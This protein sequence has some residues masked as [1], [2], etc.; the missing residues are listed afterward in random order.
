MMEYAILLL[1]FISAVFG[2]FY[3]KPNRSRRIG[4][5]GWVILSM[6]ATTTLLSIFSRYSNS[7]EIRNREAALKSSRNANKRAQSMLMAQYVDLEEPFTHAH[8]T[9]NFISNGKSGTNSFARKF[10]MEAFPINRLKKGKTIATFQFSPRELDE[11]TYI[12][13]QGDLG[14]IMIARD[15][16]SKKT[17]NQ[18]YCAG[19]KCSYASAPG[20]TW[21][22]EYLATDFGYFAQ[23]VDIQSKDPAAEFIS[24]L[25]LNRGAGDR[26]AIASMIYS[27]EAKNHELKTLWLNHTQSFFYLLQKYRGKLSKSC[28]KAI[29]IHLD[30]KV[31]NSNQMGSERMKCNKR[32]LCLRFFIKEP[33]E[34]IP[35]EFSRI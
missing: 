22:H 18:P 9:T 27:G 11:H 15:D 25:L 26:T 33:I 28:T 10:H 16:H 30:V 8:L 20:M 19:E 34:V 3:D 21:A 29:F 6:I 14:K 23:G 5:F 24:K 13:T 1:G 12:F 7:V 2:F 32:D 17:K 35:C 4:V 31:S